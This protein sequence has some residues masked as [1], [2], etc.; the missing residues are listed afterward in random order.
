MAGTF[1]ENSVEGQLPNAKG[2]LYTTPAAT[3]AILKTIS[4]VEVTG[5]NRT[6]N[7]Y[8]KRGTSRRIIPLAMALLAGAEYTK[9]TWH[10]LLAG[11]LIEGDASAVASVDYWISIVEET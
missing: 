2:T 3:K 6:V 9:E 5:N 4:L 11:D 7:I 1:T 10:H 8:L